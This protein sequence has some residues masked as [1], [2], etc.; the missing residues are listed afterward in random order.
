MLRASHPSSVNRYI[1]LSIR[2]LRY[3]GDFAGISNISET[4]RAEQHNG[5]MSVWKRLC[6]DDGM[7]ESRGWG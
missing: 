1:Y 2:F 4:G 3:R 6:C 7:D 5:P